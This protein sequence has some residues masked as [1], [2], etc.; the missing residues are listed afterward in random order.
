MATQ[1][2]A[3]H[4]IG[5]APAVQSAVALYHHYCHDGIFAALAAHVHFKQS[6]RPI[7]FVPHHVYE[8]LDAAALNLQGGDTAFLLDYVGPPGFAQRLCE[9]SDRCDSRALHV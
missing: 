2:I 4:S 3:Q 9:T 6:G 8:A 1:I 7:R 5:A